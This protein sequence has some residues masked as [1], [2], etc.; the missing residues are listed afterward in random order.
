MDKSTRSQEMLTG[1]TQ[2]RNGSLSNSLNPQFCN[3]FTQFSSSE[4]L[5]AGKF[6]QPVRDI[7]KNQTINPVFT[8]F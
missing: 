3:V 7:Q 5:I 6:Y 2:T 4:R 1:I 8:R